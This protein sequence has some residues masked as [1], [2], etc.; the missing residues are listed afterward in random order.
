MRLLDD[1]GK[2]E[3]TVTDLSVRKSAVDLSPQQNGK[4]ER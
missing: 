3:F 1:V 2:R 4:T